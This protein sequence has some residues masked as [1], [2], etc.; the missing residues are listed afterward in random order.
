MI[1]GYCR[2]STKRQSIEH[3]ER[4]IKSIYPDAVIFK[5]AF[6]G[7]KID[8]PEWN[9]LFKGVRE[10]DTIV[11]DSVS[12]MSRNAEEGLSTYFQLYNKGVTLCFLKEPHINT[13]VYRES[14]SQSIDLTGNEIADCYIEATNK[15]LKMIAE[16]Q[17]LI[18]FQQAEKEAKD[19]SKRTK[20]GLITAKLNGKTLGRQK[21]AKI[22]T[23]KSVEAKKQIKK[24]SQDFEGTLNDI[25]V[26]TLTKLSR[27][28]YY[29]YKRELKSEL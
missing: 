10:G 2:V 27:N 19:D 20:D 13:E 23:K 7:T 6:T 21:G 14:A 22:V 8:R 3:Q 28:T 24:Y 17:I 4:N 12:R 18:A 1:Y 15:V 29:K 9:K 16:R 26:M 25:D 5:E 11:F